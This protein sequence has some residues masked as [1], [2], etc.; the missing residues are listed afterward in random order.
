MDCKFLAI[1]LHLS[2]QKPRTPLL[3]AARAGVHLN[4]VDLANEA[5]VHKDLLDGVAGGGVV[6]F[7]VYYDL[8]GQV[9]VSLLVDVDVADAVC[10]AHDRDLRILLDAA[11]QRIAA[12]RDHLRMAC[13]PSR[14]SLLG[15]CGLEACKILL[16]K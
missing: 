6:Q 11:D 8:A 10:M 9:Q 2:F 13:G 3:S 14:P 16:Q 15:P 4:L 12:T 1:S 7:G 5:L